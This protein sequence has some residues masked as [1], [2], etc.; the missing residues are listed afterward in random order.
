MRAFAERGLNA[1]EPSVPAGPHPLGVELVSR[2]D[3]FHGM[4]EGFGRSPVVSMDI[5]VNA[6]ESA[7]RFYDHAI[8]TSLIE[9]AQHTFIEEKLYPALKKLQT[10]Y[11]GRN[12]Q[13]L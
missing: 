1:L 7:R 9:F 5:L 12:H 11:D 6:W 8:E 3:F 10:Y 4:A 13:L 2:A